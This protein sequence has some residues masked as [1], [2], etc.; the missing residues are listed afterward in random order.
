MVAPPE[1]RS[2]EA[3][4]FGLVEDQFVDASLRLICYEEVD[5]RRFKYLAHTNGKKFNKGSNSIRSISLQSRKA[6][7]DVGF[8]FSLSVSV[9]RY[10]YL[11]LFIFNAP[12]FLSLN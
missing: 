4:S 7:A 10:T 1:S 9:H 11:F 8:S 12:V 6:P 3:T 5:G 2:L